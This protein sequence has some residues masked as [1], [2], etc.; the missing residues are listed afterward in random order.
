LEE[1]LKLTKISII[2]PFYNE[3]KGLSTFYNRTIKVLESIEYDYELIYV[4]NC[5]QDNSVLLVL[6][7]IKEN[8]K[9]KY[10]KMSRNFGPSVEASISAGLENCSGDAAIILYS[11]LQDP[12]EVMVQFIKEWEQGFDVVYGRQVKRKGDPVWR[13]FLVR[14]YYRIF[15][16]LSDVDLPSN[17]GDFRLV[18]RKVIDALNSIPEKA[19][20]FRG[21]SSWVGFKSLA[22]DYER[23]PRL[24][25]K[26]TANL[27]V[28]TRTAFTAITSFSVKPL[29]IITF[30]GFGSLI[31]SVIFTGILFVNWLFDNSIPGLTSI[32]VLILITS[33]IN[34]L[35]L[36]IL[37]EY[38]S[39]IQTE[40][41]NR[42][43]Y[44]ID[45]KINF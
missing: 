9:I 15:A 22:V 41:K 45:S 31:T 38:V 3:E 12:P 29:R 20:Y 18:N 43:V 17:S 40:V 8:S 11:D 21:L 26:S 7:Q 36:G 39:R 44:L 19:R 16:F 24:S 4:D 33:A 10:I 1:V 30:F 32:T 23:E 35:S 2:V 25:G 34:L 13:N 5:S 14:S 28:I 6:D 27:F 37:G 42:P